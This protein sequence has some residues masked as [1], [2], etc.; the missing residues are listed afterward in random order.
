MQINAPASTLP[1]SASSLRTIS[2][3]ASLFRASRGEEP[4]GHG[5]WLFDFYATG[6]C[7]DR[8]WRF[9]GEYGQAVAAARAHARRI[10][11]AGVELLP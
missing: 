5:W 11:A 1:T 10:G 4:Q 8:G 9:S 7:L 2:V 6:Q 3:N